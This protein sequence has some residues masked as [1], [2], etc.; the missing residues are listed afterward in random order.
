MFNDARDRRTNNVPLPFED[1]KSEPVEAAQPDLLAI[2]DGEA[3]LLPEGDDAEGDG[4]VIAGEVV[5]EPV[6]L[7][8]ADSSMV[9]AAARL[10]VSTQVAST[11]MIQ[12]KLK[13]GFGRA[14]RLLDT[15]EHFGIIGPWDGKDRQVLV[16]AADLEA[17]LEAISEGRVF[18]VD[19]SG[20]DDED[21]STD[22]SEP[23][24]PCNCVC[25]EEGR[26][27]GGYDCT[28]PADDAS[29]CANFEDE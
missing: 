25:H 13:V 28:C 1:D 29:E 4:F 14:G 17:A 8:D 27:A 16:P 10:V 9:E 18:G 15:L 23:L 24:E 22:D 20:E 12:R 6:K 26:R 7:L 19:D 5:E 3:E 11:S 21:S 2:T